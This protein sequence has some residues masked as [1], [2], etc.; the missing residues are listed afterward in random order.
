M[1]II[2]L[3]ALWLLMAFG[4]AQVPFDKLRDRAW[5]CARLVVTSLLRSRRLE[6]CRQRFGCRN[7]LRRS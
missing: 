1:Q 6:R 7:R 3:H 5:H 2:N 4:N